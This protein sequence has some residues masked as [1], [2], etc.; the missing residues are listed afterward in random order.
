MKRGN[1]DGS[2]KGKAFAWKQR[3][4]HM[5]RDAAEDARCRLLM[6]IVWITLGVACA[7]LGAVLL[8]ILVR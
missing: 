7:I 6:R 5:D 1:A 2:T 8:T 4:Q 3:D